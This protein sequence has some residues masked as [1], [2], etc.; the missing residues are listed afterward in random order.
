MKLLYIV[1]LF[2]AFFVTELGLDSGPSDSRT[3]SSD[4]FIPFRRLGEHGYGR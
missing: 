2:P 3:A 1:S 4:G